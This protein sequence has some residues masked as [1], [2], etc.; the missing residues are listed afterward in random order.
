MSGFLT[1]DAW[2]CL[3]VV[4]L[5]SRYDSCFVVAVAVAVAVAVVVATV[6]TVAISPPVRQL[7]RVLLWRY[8]L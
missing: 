2:L 7:D 5:H 3:A 8:H 6:A 1:F 4:A